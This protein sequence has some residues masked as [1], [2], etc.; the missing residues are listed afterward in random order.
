MIF[1][2]NTNCSCDLVWFVFEEKF[3]LHLFKTQSLIESM[4]VRCLNWDG[5]EPVYSGRQHEYRWL[6]I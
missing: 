6:N 4:V 1:H 5:F 2:R 3:G